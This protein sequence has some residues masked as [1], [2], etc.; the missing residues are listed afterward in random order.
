VQCSEETLPC[1]VETTYQQCSFYHE[2]ISVCLCAE[3]DDMYTHRPHVKI[4]RD[5][6][7][8]IMKTSV[9]ATLWKSAIFYRFWRSQNIWNI[10]TL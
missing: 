7:I 5:Y 8:G 9:L 6:K 2:R 1:G 10:Y 4:Q 3:K